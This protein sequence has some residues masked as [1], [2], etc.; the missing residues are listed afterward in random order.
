M[1][2][3]GDGRS[4]AIEQRADA[5]VGKGRLHPAMPVEGDGRS[6]VIALRTRFIDEHLDWL[7]E[8]HRLIFSY[9][10][11]LPVSPGPLFYRAVAD[12]TVAFVAS[13]K[14]LYLKKEMA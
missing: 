4:P 6:P 7:P 11:R 13:E 14:E 3:E 2:V 9:T 8:L 5:S 10:D 12:V 1:P